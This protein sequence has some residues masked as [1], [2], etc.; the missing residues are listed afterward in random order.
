MNF[1]TTQMRSGPAA[2]AALML[3][4]A[5]V[6]AGCGDE[7][8]TAASAAGDSARATR[9]ASPGRRARAEVRS[10]GMSRGEARRCRRALG[11][12]LDA[13]ESLE[14]SVAVGVS[15]EGYLTAVNHVRASYAEADAGD[16]PL[17]CLA[18]VAAPAEAALNSYIEAANEWGE[19]L[20]DS[21]CEP[22]SVEPELQR[23]WLWAS[24]RLGKAARGLRTL[25]DD[26][27]GG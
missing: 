23:R 25:G 5:L 8:S 6:P 24:D 12:F 19:C 26:R 3:A 14:N 1:Y 27:P 2:T 4:V 10:G 20:T 18:R 9:A 15:Y 13:S 7:Q 11:D 21:A 16:L 17:L 22:E